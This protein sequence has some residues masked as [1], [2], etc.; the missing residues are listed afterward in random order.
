VSLRA[1][2]GLALG[3]LLAYLVFL[4]ASFP[5]A[6]AVAR[7]VP[8]QLGIDPGS[9]QGTVWNGALA[10]L[11]IGGSRFGPIHWSARPLRLFLGEAAYDL[12]VAGEGLKAVGQVRWSLTG[13]TLA[14]RDLGLRF[15]AGLL[16]DLGV[17]AVGLEVGLEGTAEGH[18]GRVDWRPGELPLVQGELDW[19]GAAIDFPAHLD[20]GE[21]A[22]R[23]K[24]DDDSCEISW[25]GRPG[26]VDVGGAL[27]LSP[28]LDYQVR[29]RVR[30]VRKLDASARSLLEM[31]GRPGPDGAYKLSF[32][33]RIAQPPAPPGD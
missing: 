25:D 1:G 14:V 19:K 32:A 23:A 5:A 17:L 3:T 15:P 11:A 24:A 8:P 26:T 12:D 33:G 29:L 28:P 21:V 27:T 22:V 4:V 7:W 16:H 10:S 9:V 6:V 31:L 2:L 30:P 20:L 18:L 13:G